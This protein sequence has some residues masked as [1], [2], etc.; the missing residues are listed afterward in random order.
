MRKRA[1]CRPLK[2]MD[3]VL[4]LASAF[5]GKRRLSQKSSQSHSEGGSISNLE[6]A[7]AR[8][9]TCSRLARVRCVRP[10][11][12][13]L[14]KSRWFKQI[15]SPDRH[16]GASHKGDISAGIER[17]QPPHGIDEQGLARIL[18]NT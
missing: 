17:G 15:V 14:A 11:D 6:S 12:H 4:S 9:Q 16:Q 1:A 13:G 10:E 5:L 2:A 18:G 8:L 7:A 3:H